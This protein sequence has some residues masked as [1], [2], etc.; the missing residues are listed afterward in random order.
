MAKEQE[1]YSGNPSHIHSLDTPII[2]IIRLLQYSLTQCNLLECN[3]NAYDV[4]GMQTRCIYEST[5]VWALAIFT[6]TNVARRYY[7]V[8]L[9]SKRTLYSYLPIFLPLAT[10][11]FCIL[12]LL[13][14]FDYNSN[15]ELFELF[16]FTKFLKVTMKITKWNN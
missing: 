1:D 6:S 10:I 16:S 3:C 4:V 15:A 9:T 7:E 11:S 12:N 14:R 8:W 13:S 2:L 5:K